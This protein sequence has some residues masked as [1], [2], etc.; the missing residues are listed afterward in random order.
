MRFQSE[1]GGKKLGEK[2][3]SDQENVLQTLNLSDYSP[4]ILD[5]NVM[6]CHSYHD[7]FIFDKGKSGS[8]LNLYYLVLNESCE[9]NFKDKLG[10]LDN[11]V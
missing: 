3:C 11:E 8:N 2:K 1:E 9:I 10:R 7:E 6:S 5:A 4:L